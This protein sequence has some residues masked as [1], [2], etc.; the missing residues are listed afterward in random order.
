MFRINAERSGRYC[1]GLSR[2][3]FVQIG[4]AGMGSAGL[5]QVLRAKEASAELGVP[6][7]D[8]AVILIWVDG[9]PSHMDLYDMKPEA[10]PEY[11][12]I[13]KPIPTNV[14]GVEITELFPLQAKVMRHLSLVRSVHHENGIHAPSAHWMQSRAKRWPSIWPELPQKRTNQWSS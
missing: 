13:W 5:P 12:G 4:L 8:T 7:K 6:H 9:G 10:P 1:D 14:P 3:S 11:R 2:R